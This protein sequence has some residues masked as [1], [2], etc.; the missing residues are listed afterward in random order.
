MTAEG[1]RD[2]YREWDAAYVLGALD[3]DERR[4]FEQH[5]QGCPA[6]TAAV[7]ELAGLPGMLRAVAPE[8]A[9]ALDD[10]GAA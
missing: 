1:H 6:C 9:R 4:A 7:A 5:L 2:P 8:D 10:P 3:P